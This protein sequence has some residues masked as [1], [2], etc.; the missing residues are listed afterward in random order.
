MSNPWSNSPGSSVENNK[1]PF[2]NSNKISAVNN[3]T[4]DYSHSNKGKLLEGHV[5]DNM[6]FISYNI[7]RNRM[8]THTV[9]ILAFLSGGF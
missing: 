7:G 3:D 8:F 9:F 1:S 2:Y 4:N 6:E 5:S